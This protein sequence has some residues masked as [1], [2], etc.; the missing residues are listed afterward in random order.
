[1][2]VNALLFATPGAL[3]CSERL[4]GGRTVDLLKSHWGRSHLLSERHGGCLS[5]S[6]RSSVLVAPGGITLYTGKGLGMG[7]QASS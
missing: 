5:V 3:A 4:V 7:Y 1:M 2:R 6:M